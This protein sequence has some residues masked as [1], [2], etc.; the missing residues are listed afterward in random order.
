MEGRV[1]LGD[2]LHTEKFTRP[3]TATHPS[4]NTA[5]DSR[6]SELTTC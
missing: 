1:D 5:A 3:Q 6:E 2:W 4:T